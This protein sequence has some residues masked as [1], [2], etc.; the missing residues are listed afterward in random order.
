MTAFSTLANYCLSTV[1]RF[2]LCKPAADGVAS[3]VRAG[4]Q[5]QDAGGRDCRLA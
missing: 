3:R 5:D 1:L 4:A 2:V